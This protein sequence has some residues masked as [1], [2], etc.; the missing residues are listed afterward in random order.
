MPPAHAGSSLA[1][2]QFPDILDDLVDLRVA[3][4][5]TECRHRARLSVLNTL[6]NKLVVSLCIH[7]L[8]PLP[9]SAATIGMT[10]SAG[11]CEQLANID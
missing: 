7:E 3:E 4:H 6:P 1:R 5:Q 8:R 9:G 11:C 10:P 2:P